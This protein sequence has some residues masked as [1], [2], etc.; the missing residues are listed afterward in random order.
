MRMFAELMD[1]RKNIK[2]IFESGYF[3]RRN[4]EG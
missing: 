2:K 4:L 3:D 1:E